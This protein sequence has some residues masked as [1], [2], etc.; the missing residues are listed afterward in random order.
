MNGEERKRTPRANWQHQLIYYG[1]RTE[2]SNHRPRVRTLGCTD[3]FGKTGCGFAKPC[4]K[5]RGL[6][7]FSLFSL[8]CLF[9]LKRELCEPVGALREFRRGRSL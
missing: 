3:R 6:A 1:P 8:Y 7:P 4:E 9:T 2:A 5:L